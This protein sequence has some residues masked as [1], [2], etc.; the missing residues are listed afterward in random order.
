M[1]TLLLDQVAWD[2]VLDARGNIAVASNPYSL[3]QDAASAIRTFVGEC[4][5]DT[6]EGIPYLQI[7][8]KNVPVPL[9]KQYFVDT[10]LTVPGVVS[11]Q[12][13][14]SDLSDRRLIGQVQIVSSDGDVSAAPI[15]VPVNPQGAG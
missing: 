13:F 9:L 1:D 7:L 15:F 2:L 4:Y 6:I 3:A 10:A 12:V 11:A 8:G 14:L 5:F